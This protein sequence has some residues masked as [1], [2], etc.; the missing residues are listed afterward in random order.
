MSRHVILA[1]LLVVVPIGAQSQERA[2]SEV[3]KAS[4]N[5]LSPMISLP[6]QSSFNYGTGIPERLQYVLD[7][8]PVV[9][10]KITGDLSLIMRVITPIVQQPV[11]SSNTE[12]GMGDLTVETFLAPARAAERGFM[13]GIGPALTPPTATS[14][15]LGAERWAAGVST[16]LV[17]SP[18][19]WV[20]GM[21][22]DQQWSYAGDE[23]RPVTNPFVLQPFINYNFRS[24]WSIGT[25]PLITADWA[26]FDD[27]LF[28]PIGGGV[29]KVFSIGSQFMSATVHAYTN[30]V[31][32]HGMSDWTLR[33]T[34][35]LL[36]PQ[37]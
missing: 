24:G 10:V 32:R 16:V 13:W 19:E 22:V 7:V 23:E 28:V 9:P 2:T 20:L 25:S 4:Q 29:A 27:A 26:Q 31:R 18:D 1:V 33:A 14:S 21:L 8:Q 35:S 30:A 36:F 6:L 15:V 5:P 3:A 17:M 12:T 34:Y 37:L 11:G